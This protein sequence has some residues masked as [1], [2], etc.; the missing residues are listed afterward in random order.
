MKK[1][2]HAVVLLK[3]CGLFLAIALSI[4]TSRAQGM[5][6]DTIYAIGHTDTPPGMPGG[7]Q[8]FFQILAKNYR[9]PDGITTDSLYGSEMIVSFMVDSSGTTS[10]F[11]V[12][13]DICPGCGAALVKCLQAMPPWFPARK[14]GIPVK[15]RFIL[16][17]RVRV[18]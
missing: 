13:K 10:H 1:T 5:V 17:F 6:S 15:T 16:P 2:E 14:G 11:Q 7:E 9:L 8:R 18:E 4:F 12:E 3:I